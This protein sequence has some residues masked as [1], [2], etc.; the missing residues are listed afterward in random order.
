MT[1]EDDIDALAAEY[2]LG[3]LNGAE[4]DSVAARAQSDEVLARAIADWEGRL[5]QL[6][7]ALYPEVEPERADLLSRVNE[8]IDKLDANRSGN[9][10]IVRLQRSAMRWRAGAIAMT[11]MA[12]SLAIVLGL[13]EVMW[14][15]VPT[16]YVAVLQQDDM[17]P[18][19]LL[20]IDTSTRN[21]IV[22]PVSA[23]AERGKNFELWLVHSSLKTP[24]SLGLLSDKV[25]MQTE[26]YSDLDKATFMD[27][28]Y[29][30]SVEPEGGSKTGA[31]TGPVIF[32]GKLIPASS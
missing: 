16:T 26:I 8:R 1:T 22:R 24:R 29:A 19:F 30:V 27:A 23:P 10:Q 20:S 11:A 14:R 18:A 32:A 4:R 15:Q 31:P 9:A 21:V 13:R 3:T 2:V 28:T 7:T 12:A 25:P 17:S 6:A 5:S